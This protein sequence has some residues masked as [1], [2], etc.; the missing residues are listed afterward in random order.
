MVAGLLRGS[1]PERFSGA[2]LGAGCVSPRA[3][4]RDAPS[5]MA[6][7]LYA[8]AIGGQW[9]CRDASMHWLANRCTT[10]RGIALDSGRFNALPP[11]ALL[12]YLVQR[13]V[14][15]ACRTRVGD[16]ATRRIRDN[17]CYR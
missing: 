14:I 17:A 11:S 5:V 12:L 16:V 2:E 15:W 8:G 13:C 4:V 1:E 6:S 7:A 10:R 9:P 3:R